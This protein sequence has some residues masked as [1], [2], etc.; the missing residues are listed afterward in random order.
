MENFN[1]KNVKKIKPFCNYYST[2]GVSICNQ[3]M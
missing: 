3:F 2:V 1:P